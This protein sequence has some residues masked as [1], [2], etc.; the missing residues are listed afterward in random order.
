MQSKDRQNEYS[1]ENLENYIKANRSDFIFVLKKI[2]T[3]QLSTKI[4][5]Y[6]LYE[7][8]DFFKT[9]GGR[10][11]NE[12]VVL[13]QF[14]KFGIIRVVEQYG[15]GDDWNFKIKIDDKKLDQISKTIDQQNSK[16]VKDM[17]IV[18]ILYLDRDGTLY[19]NPRSK[20][21]YELNQG[22]NRYKILRFLIENHG[23]QK[24]ISLENELGI[25]NTKSIRPEIGKI[26]AK[27]Q[28]NLKIQNF[29]EGKKGSGYRISPLYKVDLED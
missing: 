1:G 27:I 2:Q 20:Y 4:G 22:S 7:I 19:R 12:T 8:T 11:M 16:R 15:E 29:I 28:N 14:S 10:K 18:S 13:N 23:Y 17:K 5:H 25:K 6:C 3:L 26:K 9:K 21:H 24:V